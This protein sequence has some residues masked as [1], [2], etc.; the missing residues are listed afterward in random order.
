MEKQRSET[1]PLIHVTCYGDTLH[2][3]LS[4]EMNHKE[5]D[6]KIVVMNN[7]ENNARFGTRYL[8]QRW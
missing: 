8:S 3:M 1:S 2:L 4:V 5:R 7:S 6:N